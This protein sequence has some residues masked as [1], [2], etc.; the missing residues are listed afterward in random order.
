MKTEDMDSEPVAVHPNIMVG[1]IKTM[2]PHQWTKN[3]LIFA[4]L[5]FDGQLTV[6]ESLLRVLVGFGLLCLM[7][8]SIYVINDLVDVKSDR[9]HPKKRHR[10][11]A[12]G[13]LPVPAATVA[14]FVLPVF[15]LVGGLLMAPAFALVL[16]VY[17]MLHVAYSFRLKHV[18]LIDILSIA[19]GFVLRIAAGATLIEVARFSPWLYVC[20]ITLSLFLAVGKRRQE[21][22]ELGSKA[23]QVRPV[24]AHYTTDFLNETLRLALTSTFITYVI[25]TVETP[26]EIGDTEF[27]A[28]LTIPFVLYGLLRY[29]F[30]IS[31]KGIGSAP[32]EVLLKD[33]P[34]QLAILGWMLLF[35]GL[36]YL[37]V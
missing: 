19:A 30:L 23:A 10:P 28:I 18:P 29:Q 33:R 17:F 8:S 11:I 5:F 31:V 25:Y 9:M 21:F 15:A 13:L 37:S 26:I 27:G 4:P 22:I 3:A 34:L 12:S 2:R 35:M 32:D 1:L 16:A 7:A 24:F 20:T 14:A 6:L 36:I